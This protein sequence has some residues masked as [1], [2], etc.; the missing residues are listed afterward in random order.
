M[1]T[2]SQPRSLFSGIAYGQWAYWC[3]LAMA[4]W[5]GIYMPSGSIRSVIIATPV[6]PAILIVAVSYWIYAASDE[7]FRV[8]LLKSAVVTMVAVGL[9]TLAYFLLELFGYPKLSMLWVNLVGMSIFNLQM[10]YLISR[11]K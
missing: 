10:L 2:V 1:S 5:A 7:Y 8:R 9:C 6:L 11:A 3:T 4:A